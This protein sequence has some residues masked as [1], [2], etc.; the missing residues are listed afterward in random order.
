MALVITRKYGERVLIGEDIEV[1]ITRTGY[2]TGVV[3]L[4]IKAPRHVKV[5]RDELAGKE[6][7]K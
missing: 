2:R 4:A 5:L 3:R 6:A 7:K 1:T